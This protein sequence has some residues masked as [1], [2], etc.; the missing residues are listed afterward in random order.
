MTEEKKSV[1]PPV[2]PKATSSRSPSVGAGSSKGGRTRARAAEAAP[3]AIRQAVPEKSAAPTRLPPPPPPPLPFPR[4]EAEAIWPFPQVTESIDRVVHAMQGR[5]TSGISP[6]SMGLAYFDWLVHLANSPGKAS[7]LVQNAAAKSVGFGLYAA[8]ALSNPEEELPPFIQPLPQDTRFSSPEWKKYPFSLTHQAFLLTEQWWHYATTEMKGVSR[9]HQDVVS[10]T[11]RQ[12]LD[13]MAPSNF[14]IS[15]PDILK[16][17]IEQKGDNL[18]RGFRKFVDNLQNQLSGTQTQGHSSRYVVGETVAVTEGRVIYRNRLIE[19]I[20]YSPATDKVKAEPVLIVP[21]WIMKY[22]ILDLSAHNSLVKYLVDQGHTVFVISWKNPDAEDRDMG[23]EDYLEL[24][25]MSSLDAIGHVCPKAKVHTVGYCLGGTLATIAT[26]A[27]AR[28]GDDRMASLTLFAAQVDFEEAGE[29]MLF[30]DDSQV[31]YLED[32]MWDRGYLDTKQMVGAFQLL[33]SNDLIWS[34]LIRTY[35]L[36]EE[37]SLNDLMAWNADATRM[38]YRMHSEYLRRLFV[39]NDLSKGRFEVK[40]RPVALSDIRVP[41][42][43]VATTKDHVAPWRSVFKINLLSDTEVTFILTGG[44]HNAGIVSEPGHR[45]RS[46][47]MAAHTENERFIDPDTWMAITPR[48]EG[49][50]WLAWEQWLNQHSTAQVEPPQMGNAK[51]G[52]PPLYAAPGY[53]VRQR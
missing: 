23:M 7:E 24:G 15:N 29:I 16:V 50:W 35:Y 48:Q 46:F 53:Y 52:Y 12:I 21:A 34:Q 28:D 19:L 41:I 25:V 32:M 37:E 44:G 31:S 47:Q 1:A 43:A 40:G 45:G 4:N 26:A 39:G 36:G 8:R 9:H 30:I 14:P 49:S 51:A 13:M 27:M 22:Y 17:T 42:L 3:A 20:Q 18:G 6:A 10:F 11:A 33:R 38:P 2:A 5:F